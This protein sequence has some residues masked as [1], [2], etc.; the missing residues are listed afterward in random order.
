MMDSRPL[1]K[2]DVELRA[3]ALFNGTTDRQLSKVE[4][5]DLMG[6]DWEGEGISSLMESEW[7]FS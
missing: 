1:E 2:L 4:L 5:P 3:Q 6:V 7:F